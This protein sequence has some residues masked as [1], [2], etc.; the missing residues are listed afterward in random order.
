LAPL[1][2]VERAAG[3]GGKEEGANLVGHRRFAGCDRDSP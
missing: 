1:V 2:G 3:G